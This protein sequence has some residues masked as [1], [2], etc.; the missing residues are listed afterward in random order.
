MEKRKMADVQ[1]I[2]RQTG[3]KNR[4]GMCGELWQ[5]RSAKDLL[6]SA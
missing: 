6:E 5:R 4:W 2:T 1:L 3:K